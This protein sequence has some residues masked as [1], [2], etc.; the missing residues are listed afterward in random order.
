MTKRRFRLLF[1]V[2]TVLTVGCLLGQATPA[3]MVSPSVS[4]LCWH[5]GLARNIGIAETPCP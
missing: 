3:V 5:P 4:D 2:A 1:T